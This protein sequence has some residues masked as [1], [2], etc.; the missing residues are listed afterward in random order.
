MRESVMLFSLVHNSVPQ[1]VTKASNYCP[2]KEVFPDKVMHRM[3][4]F[5]ECF[6]ILMVFSSLTS[7]IAAII[8]Q[9]QDKTVTFWKYRYKIIPNLTNYPML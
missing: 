4:R 3:V 5:R 8:G 7:G 9:N 1:Y 2:I 6:D